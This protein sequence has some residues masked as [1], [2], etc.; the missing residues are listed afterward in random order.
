MI[1]QLQTFVDNHYLSSKHLTF[2]MDELPGYISLVFLATT[3]ATLGFVFYAI[4]EVKSANSKFLSVIVL[5]GLLTWLALTGYL[6]Y[7]GFYREFEAMPPRL[8]FAIGPANLLIIVLL[9]VKKSRDY[10][11]KVPI[12]ILTYL[13][14]I[15]IPI[16]M[17]LWWLALSGAVPM[18]LTFEGVN[19]DILSGVT[20][21]FVAIFFVSEKR[22]NRIAAILWN[23]IT[24][25]LLI[26]IVGHAL[27]SAPTPFQRFN[28]DNP[29]MAPFYLPYIWL[30]AFIVPAVFFSHLV[31]L[32]QLFSKKEF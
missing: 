25:G 4:R 1:W 18:M 27:L 2:L 31:S 7:A 28:F 26:N 20:A 8:L 13:H 12:S 23:L 19:Y 21:P 10:L 14:I 24:L 11:M 15:R 32:V 5:L 17:V 22:N 6:A 29:V 3:L 30:P 9:A 16:E